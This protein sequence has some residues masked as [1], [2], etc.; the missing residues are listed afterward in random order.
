M[1]WSTVAAAATTITP[2]PREHGVH[3]RGHVPWLSSSCSCSWSSSFPRHSLCAAAQTSA[4]R[5]V[6]SNLWD[7]LQALLHW[8]G[9]RSDSRRGVEVAERERS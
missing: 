2:T 8:A 3:Q 7:R 9:L 1:A 5:A 6:W 4:T